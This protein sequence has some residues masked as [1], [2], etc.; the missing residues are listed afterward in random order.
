MA[1][2]GDVHV[3]SM[4]GLVRHGAWQREGALTQGAKPGRSVRE[5]IRSTREYYR[6]LLNAPDAEEI[7]ISIRRILGKR[8]GLHLFFEQ[9]W[10]LWT[11]QPPAPVLKAFSA[12]SGELS[13]TKTLLHFL[14]VALRSP[15]GYQ[16]CGLFSCRLLLYPGPRKALPGRSL[17]SLPSSM[18]RLPFTKTSLRPTE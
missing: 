13:L 1:S 17:V 3:T 4:K 14:A 9:L 5:Q 2:T 6:V 12:I 18:T 10:R 15:V 7:L 8:V 11:T 16:D